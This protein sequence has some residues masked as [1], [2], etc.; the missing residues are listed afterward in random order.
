MKD[1]LI[2]QKPETSLKPTARCLHGA[3]SPLDAPLCA[4]SGSMCKAG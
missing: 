2:A 1:G 3:P 4:G